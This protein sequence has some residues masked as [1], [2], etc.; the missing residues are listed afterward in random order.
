MNRKNICIYS[1]VL[2]FVFMFM[3]L[4]T[5]FAQSW[6][7]FT[8]QEGFQFPKSPGSILKYSVKEKSMT[9]N[10]AQAIAER[11]GVKSELEV[12]YIYSMPPV[13][14]PQERGKP[15]EEKDDENA[16]L[17]KPPN[18]IWPP[19][20]AERTTKIFIFEDTKNK[21]FLKIHSKNGLLT[22]SNLQHLRFDVRQKYQLSD[23]ESLEVVVSFLR[24]LK[25]PLKDF[26]DVT[27]S[28]VI[29]NQ[30]QKG[31]SEKILRSIPIMKEVT[32]HKI[33]AAGADGPRL[34]LVGGGGT[35]RGSV[36]LTEGKGQPGVGFISLL[37]RELVQEQT[38]QTIVG[39][40]RAFSRLQEG[41]NIVNDTLRF[42]SEGDLVLK[43]AYLAYYSP[44]GTQSINELIPVWCFQTYDSK[45]PAVEVQFY[46]KAL[47]VSETSCSQMNED[48]SITI[49]CA[50]LESLDLKFNL[51]FAYNLLM[52]KEGLYWKL[53]I[54]SLQLAG[55]C[56][57]PSCT[58]NL[59]LDLSFAC[60]EYAGIKLQCDLLY[61]GG[62][63][64]DPFGHY[65]QL[66]VDS[67]QLAK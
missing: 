39:A 30:A 17:V 54:N 33:L 15:T 47:D 46:V 4:G 10:Q 20:G 11:L 26:N 6:P 28:E 62:I 8:T 56:G 64:E 14:I 59:Q 2:I 43:N 18:I 50:T 41:Q 23:K 24:S 57:S 49:P 55:A 67:L 19:P 35:I 31:D 58:M 65:W 52:V 38:S 7:K 3:G 13:S 44:A 34:P 36:G 22:Y 53:D 60:L 37:S 32:I 9:E 1:L 51:Q 5:S 45:N 48:L 42:Y 63:G 12:D 29:L 66:D 16:K 25:A 27:Y 21:K 40:E 61:Q